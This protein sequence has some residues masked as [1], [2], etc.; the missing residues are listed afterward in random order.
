MKPLDPRLL[1]TAAAARTYVLVAAALSVLAAVCIIVQA[2]AIA[3]ALGPVAL[4]EADLAGIAAPLAVLAGAVAGR[5]LITWARERIGAGAAVDVV[6]QLRTRLLSHATSLGHRWRVRHGDEVTLLATRGL[7]DVGPYVTGYLPQLLMTAILTPLGLAV[8]LWLDLTSGLIVAVTL[9]LVP[10]F[11]W[12]IGR[13]TASYSQRRLEALSAQGAQLLDLLA[14][15]TTLRALGRELG[16]G[17]RVARLG[18]A[19]RSTTMQTLRVAF[20][21]GAVLE[22]LASLSVALVAVEVGMRLVHGN[23]DLVTGLTVLVLAPE[24]YA[25]LRQVGTQFHASTN[26]LAAVARTFAVLDTP[27]PARGSAPVPAWEAIELDHLSVIADERGYHAPHELFGTVLPGRLTALA[28]P[29]GAGKTTAAMALLALQVPDGGGV[30]LRAGHGV[31]DLAEVD[32][33]AW[34][35]QA[36]WVPQRIHTAGGTVREHVD[37]TG[38]LPQERLEDAARLT[39]LADA[40]GELPQGWDTPLASAVGA[41]SSGLSVG[42]TH[43]LELTRAVV[44]GAR[45]VVLDEPTAHLAPSDE[46]GVV[47]AM[48]ALARAG[49]AVVV[50][51]HRPATLAAADTV[52]QVTAEAADAAD[53][54]DAVT[55]AG[56]G[57]ARTTSASNPST[58][59]GAT[60]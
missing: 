22:L 50:V 29:S 3:R 14:G 17:T 55:A 47:H 9:P 43:R 41:L 59:S 35:E 48:Q 37:P 7:E 28:G 42:Q 34:W 40:L 52:I 60:S 8:M 58:T 32:P 33:A 54:A 1:R 26:G 53:A 21:S 56:A 10:L 15:L 11:M 39:G 12:L 24:I 44:R 23:L 45:L 51:A 31:V 27:L 20:L 36:A 2:F 19:Y 13:T 4:G 38:R 30:R 6:A 18:A 25:P 49:A 16:P 46:A 5:T 57:Q